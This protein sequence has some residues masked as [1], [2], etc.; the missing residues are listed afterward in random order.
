MSVVA[1]V[2][3]VRP[4]AMTPAVI[5]PTTMGAMPRWTAS[6]QGEPSKWFQTRETPKV[7]TEAGRKNPPKASRAPIDAGDVIADDDHHQ[8][9]RARGE[10]AQAVDVAE[11]V[12]A[13]PMIGFDGQRLHLR[14]H[15]GAPA[16]GED[17]KK[18]EDAEQVEIR[19]AGRGHEGADIYF[20]RLLV[21]ARAVRGQR[22][23]A[24]G[25]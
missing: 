4:M 19:M 17:G 1:P 16:D 3:A 10:L 11:L 15:R 14:Q 18:G 5:S 9:V 22:S 2:M 6:R 12:V 23:C 24:M 21:G 13:Q 8:H 25:R 20:R 7:S